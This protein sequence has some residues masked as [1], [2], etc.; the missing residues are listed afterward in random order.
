MD[1]RM[2]YASMTGTSDAAKSSA[3]AGTIDCI[4]SRARSGSAMVWCPPGR[5]EWRIP[6]PLAMQFL[7]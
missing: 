6:W 1:K 4:R 7:R 5:L 3:K 2:N